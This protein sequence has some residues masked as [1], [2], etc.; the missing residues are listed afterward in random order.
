MMLLSVVNVSKRFGDVVALDAVSIDIN[1]GEI[2][3]LLGENGSGKSTLA[4]IIYGVYVPDDGYIVLHRDGGVHRVFFTSPKDAIK[5]GIVMISQRPQL[6]E[7][8]TIIDNIALFLGLSPSIA[9][10]VVELILNKF[11][12][13][14][15]LRKIVSTLSYTEKQ[16][17]ELVKAL[18]FKPRLLI[19]DE[20]TTYLPEDVKRSFY[21]VLRMFV[22]LGGSIMF[23][24][25]KIPEAL[26]ICDRIAILRRGK[27]IGV[28]NKDEGLS[29]DLVRKTM[30]VEGIHE[31]ITHKGFEHANKVHKNK[32]V[33]D[34]EGLIILD[35]YGRRAVDGISFSIARGQVL[36]VVG[37]AGNGQKELCEGV[38]GL[39][40]ALSGKIILDG[41]DVTKLNAAKRVFKG[42]YYIPEDPFKDGVAID[43]TIAEN[44]RLFSNRKISDI[45]IDR[46]LKE[47]KVQPSNPML[48][49]Y[50]LS[51]GNVQKISI[52]KLRLSKPK[53]VIIYNPTRMLDEA[54]SHFVK[55]MLR[56]LAEKG[57]GILLVSEDIDEV[58]DMAD[59]IA[60]ISRGQI[61]KSF[62]VVDLNV[63]EEI[64]K[65]MMLYG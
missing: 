22:S 63:R 64:K 40:R 4:K 48:K 61:V 60:V 50:K 33:L 5:Y 31:P 14:L 1:E 46:I 9:R 32:T 49:V 21:E 44:L 17:V 19:V 34:V 8:L 11:N 37:V 18:S 54:S 47:F 59:E 12:I 65:A 15:D 27:L 43:L 35:E 25:H 3:G 39:R 62:N 58:I 6:I 38:A 52:A 42:L 28:F 23:I 10:R 36:A 29:I 16:F 30:F 2:L 57:I 26:E 55:T 24:T 7:E 51:G 53:C 20:A 41:E 13:K 56:G 45:D